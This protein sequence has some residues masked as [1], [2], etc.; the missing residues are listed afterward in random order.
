MAIDL[1]QGGRN[2]QIRPTYLG[3]SK[4]WIYTDEPAF[5]E[6][7]VEGTVSQI[8]AGYKG[9]LSI[10]LY[11]TINAW[12]IYADTTGSMV[13]DVYKLTRDQYLA[14]TVPS[15]ANTIAGSALPTVTSNVAARSDTLTG[16]TTE[17]KQNDYVAFNVNSC[18]GILRASIILEC[19][20]NIGQ[21]SGEGT[22]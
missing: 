21:F 2:Q 8:S 4:G 7:V 11:L 18:T 17:I 1:D 14:G 20:K 19:V 15:V 16:W 9:G 6:F 10:P 13:V 5:I 12:A 22:S 3:P